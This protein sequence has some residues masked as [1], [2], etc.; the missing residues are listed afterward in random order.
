MIFLGRTIAPLAWLWKFEPH[1]LK[2]EVAMKCKKN[3]YSEE[4]KKC[5]S[6]GAGQNHLRLL[7]PK[8]EER[9]GVV[10]YSFRCGKCK[11]YFKE[12]WIN[13]KLRMTGGA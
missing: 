1:I 11:A 12:Y 4:E 3:M 13:G 7:N 2:I 8:G 9:G 10:N 6:C 5:L